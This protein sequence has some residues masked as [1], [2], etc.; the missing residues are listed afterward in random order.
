MNEAEA[1]V[2]IEQLRRAIERH[3]R[4]YY[5][6]N[7]PEITDAAYDELMRRL[8][9][10]E[11]AFPDLVTPASPTQRVGGAPAEGFAT[12]R[13]RSPML[14]LSN[15]FSAEEVRAFDT[16]VRRLLDLPVVEYVAEPK[17]DGLGV[18]LT[19]ERGV[20]TRGATRGDGEIGED[21]TGN[22]RTVRSVPLRLQAQVSCEVRGEVFM[23]KADFAAL[24]VRREEA[25]EAV[26]ANLIE[27]E[28]LRNDQ[29]LAGDLFQFLLLLG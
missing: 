29:G 14:S 17:I 25:G 21:V 10:L 16:R 6:L 22:L 26:F 19:Y 18:S 9:E 5:V 12:V 1:R 28:R 13:H 3:D 20:L 11:R 23:R 8:Q 4:L 27:G 24:N 2:E 7:R 15:A